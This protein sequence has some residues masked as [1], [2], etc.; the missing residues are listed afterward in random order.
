MPDMDLP[1]PPPRPPSWQEPLAARLFFGA[2]PRLARVIEPD[3]PEALRPWENVKVERGGAGSLGGTWYP[4]EGRARGAVLLMHPWTEW[5]RSYFHRRGRIEALRAAGYH[6]LA[7]DLGSFGGARRQPGFPDRDIEPALAFLRQRAGHLPLHL[8]GVSAGGYWSH[9]VLSREPGVLGAMF[10][11]VS[12]HL[13]EWSWRVA[14]W[15]RPFYLFFRHAFAAS[16]RYMDLRLHA[17]ALKVAAAGYVSGGRDRGV[18]PGDT[19][20]LAA[21]AG[22]PHLIVPGAD[23][24]GAIKVASAEVIGFALDT[25][26]RAEEAAFPD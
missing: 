8:W 10:E 3:P 12:P 9:L 11:D 13:L 2:G 14:P 1:A 24:L 23:H 21:A 6:S 19:R 26:R 17:P 15:G 18:R 25:F 16:Y 4:V 5:G 22:A 20:T 7:V